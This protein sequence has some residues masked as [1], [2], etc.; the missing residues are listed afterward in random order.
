MRGIRRSTTLV[1][2]LALMC[3]A[4]SLSL[5]HANAQAPT[6]DTYE[7]NDSLY[8]A[9]NIPR[10]VTLPNPSISPANDPDYYRFIAVPGP[11]KIE[12][13]GTPGLDLTLELLDGT[14]AAITS[15]N[16][17]ASPNAV[18]SLTVAAERYYAIHIANGTAFEGFYELRVFNAAPTA[19]PTPTSTTTPVPTGTLIPTATSVFPTNT[20]TPDQ[21][22]VPDFTEPN[23]NFA[24]AYRIAP[25]DRLTELNFNSGSY[26]QQDNDFFVMAV[27][28]GVSYT[29]RTDDL[30]PSVDS[31]LIIYHSANVN[32]VVGGND[33]QNTQ[34]GQ[35]NSHLEFTARAE[36]DVYVLVGYKYPQTE[37]IRYP[38]RAT[39]TLT[40]FASASTP[41]PTAITVSGGNRASML[42]TPRATPI[43]IQLIQRPETTPTST[44]PPI[45]M[46]TIDVLVAYDKNANKKVDPNEGTV[47]VSVR[48]LDAITNREMSHS[49]TNTTG[50]V[51][52]IVATNAPVR[53]VIPFLNAAQDFRPGSLAQWTLLIPASISPGLIP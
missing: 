25:G 37:D 17:P 32:D 10:S 38:G 15:A 14:G 8:E 53:V 36:G 47:G 45:G 44:P 51:R 46:M 34:A 21:G 22:G 26:G 28:A 41:T 33:D 40:C 13:I 39:Y 11:L 7:E 20:P 5:P 6:P 18:I 29:C 4:A 42:S 30:G 2:F 43:S 52:F 3:M 9:S 12:V 19:T 23:F 35:I 31:N 16:D 49:F 27:R 1:L 50:A 48:V 24:T